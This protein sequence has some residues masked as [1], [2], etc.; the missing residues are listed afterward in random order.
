MIW[1]FDR[2][3]NEPHEASIKMV[4]QERG[5]YDDQIEL[6]LA[7]EVEEPGSSV[8]Q[9]LIKADSISS[10]DRF[11]LTFYVG[12]MLKRVPDR[13]QRALA[14]LP[15]LVE[16]TKTS[17]YQKLIAM[18]EASGASS[19]LLREKLSEADTLVEQFAVEPPPVIFEQIRT[20]WP[21]EKMLEAIYRMTW[22][23]L[24]T[25]GPLYYITTDNPVF[26]FRCWGLG[27]L[28]SEL[29]FPLS[30]T[31]ALHGSF[32]PT[33][34]N[35]TYCQARRSFVRE[36][37]RRLASEATRF[38]FHHQRT[39]WITNLLRNRNPHLSRIQW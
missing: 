21:T 27:T 17:V 15:S 11:H 2:L 5:F 32:Q 36:V 19:E 30:T 4:A 6:Q 8:I 25:D 9:K 3:G 38:A 33:E 24:V 14:L 31:H 37:N 13:R 18:A 7:R 22:R 26:F 34:S 29:T 39:E 35:L 28:N 1:M 20:P 10:L 23:V 12:T 16:D